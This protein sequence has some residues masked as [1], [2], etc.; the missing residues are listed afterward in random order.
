MH[1]HVNFTQIISNHLKSCHVWSCQNMDMS[2]FGKRCLQRTDAALQVSLWD[3]WDCQSVFAKNHRTE[4][5][6]GW[7]LFANGRL[8]RRWRTSKLIM[9]KCQLVELYILF[10]KF[11]IM[12][13]FT[14]YNCTWHLFHQSKLKAVACRCPPFFPFHMVLAGGPR[15]G[16]RLHRCHPETPGGGPAPPSSCRARSAPRC[17]SPRDAQL[18]EQPCRASAAAGEARW[19]GPEVFG[20][21]RWP[22]WRTFFR[23]IFFVW[24][25]PEAWILSFRFPN[26][27]WIAF[28]GVIHCWD[29]H[30]HFIVVIGKM[31]IWQNC[32]I[33]RVNSCKCM[34]MRPIAYIGACWMK[35]WHLR[36]L[37][38]ARRRPSAA[39]LLQGA[40]RTSVRIT[41]GRSPPWTTWR[42]SWS[43]RGSWLRLG[44]GL[45]MEGGDLSGRFTRALGPMFFSFCNCWI[46]MESW[47]DMNGLYYIIFIVRASV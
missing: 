4:A 45:W 44:W 18:H 21:E 19:G 26:I 11:W 14:W 1:E 27:G 41:H 12:C 40:K 42:T 28:L 34:Q 35:V 2:K 8:E 7:S 22:S 15:P 13:A 33:F 43:S 47:M 24:P 20:E 30:P 31:K 6:W 46:N 5:L 32:Q 25:R 16:A 39:E 36:H 3:V 9:L 37:R 23:G 10:F 38:D 17:E 29:F